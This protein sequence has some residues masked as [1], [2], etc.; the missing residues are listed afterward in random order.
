MI[1]WQEVRALAGGFQW[2]DM[3]AQVAVEREDGLYAA[4][5]LPRDR[6]LLISVEWD[7]QE[8]SS[9]RWRF[10]GLTVVAEKD[11]TAPPGG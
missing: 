3:E 5:G 9:E 4:C 2:H 8:S 6:W 10:P 11:M 1:R 7:G